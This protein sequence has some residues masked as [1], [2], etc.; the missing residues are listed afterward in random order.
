MA[1]E[2]CSMWTSTWP[3]CSAMTSRS[4]GRASFMLN[5]VVSPS[6]TT[7]PESPIGPSAGARNAMIMMS[8]SPL[9]P[10]TVVLTES[11]VS[12]NLVNP[13]FSSSRLRSGTG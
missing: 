10:L 6:E 12:T 13:S 1:P 7:R 11:V 2:Y 9:G 5:A 4:I 8:R 3:N